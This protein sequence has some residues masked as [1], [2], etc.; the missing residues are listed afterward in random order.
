MLPELRVQI[1]IHGHQAEERTLTA[2]PKATVI[3]FLLEAVS[4]MKQ[5]FLSLAKDF[6]SLHIPPK[7][8]RAMTTT[9]CVS[10]GDSDK[11][12]SQLPALPLLLMTS[13]LKQFSIPLRAEQLVAV[14]RNITSSKCQGAE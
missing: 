10:P 11:S 7:R 5:Y 1:S 12:R 9:L 6:L 2:V 8:A 4:E 13:Q 3:P 14:Q